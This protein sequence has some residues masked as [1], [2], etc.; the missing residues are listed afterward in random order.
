MSIKNPLRSLISRVFSHEITCLWFEPKTQLKIYCVRTKGRYGAMVAV[1]RTPHTSY[2]LVPT[3]VHRP[4]SHSGM[5]V[6]SLYVQYLAYYLF[7]SIVVFTLYLP[8]QFS[9]GFH[10]VTRLCILTTLKL[11]YPIYIAIR[12][13]TYYFFKLTL[14]TDKAPNSHLS[15]ALQ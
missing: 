3:K 1:V 8:S 2:T 9:W 5:V 4:V 15:G 14:S 12:V 10:K 6:P 11:N 13:S 7:L